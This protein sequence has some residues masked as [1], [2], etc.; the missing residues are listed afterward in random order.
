MKFL[1]LGLFAFLS[2]P[3]WAQES[4]SAWLARQWEALTPDQRSVTQPPASIP[5][6]PVDREALALSN[7]HVARNRHLNH[8]YGTLAMGF[9]ACLGPQA[10]SWYH[11]AHFA[12]TSSGKFISGERLRDLDWLQRAGL[13]V[14]ARLRLVPGQRELAALLGQTNF[15]IGVE[16]VPA[17]KL[18]LATFCQGGELLPYEVF[19]QHLEGGDRARRELYE[20]FQYYHAALGEA[21]PSRKL[22]LV[23]Y[24]TTLQMMGEQRRAQVSVDAVFRFGDSRRGPWEA[25]YRRAAAASAGLELA[26]GVTIPFDR[27]VST[28][29]MEAEMA[30]LS[31]EGWRALHAELGVALNPGTTFAGTAVTDWGDLRQRLAFLVAVARAHSTR[32]ELLAVP[33]L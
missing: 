9:A 19:G 29:W 27:D 5:I 23:V 12:S 7:D 4:E 18:F 11:Y 1:A 2:A 22:A 8:T 6:D 10:G 20:A 25:Y 13:G 26:A 14:L 32:P 24:G 31:F 17:G 3:V 16:M 30:D 28:Q 21:D 15:L 33:R